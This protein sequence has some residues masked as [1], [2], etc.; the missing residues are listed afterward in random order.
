MQYQYTAYKADRVVTN[1][2]VEAVSEKMAEDFLYQAGYKYVLNLK[3]KPVKKTVSQLI[4][5][6]FGVKTRDIIDFTRQLASFLDSGS[7]LIVALELLKD[8]DTK[9]ALREVINNIISR[10]KQGIPFSQVIKENPEI[11]SFSYYQVISSCEKT[12]D[13]VKGL[14][15]IADY[16]EQKAATSE[17]IKRALVYPIFVICLAIGVVVLMIT[18]VLPPIIKLFDS[19]QADLPPFTVLALALINF[20]TEY[21]VVL[22]II[23]VAIVAGFWLLS[24]IP[25]GRLLLDKWILKTPVFGQIVLQNSLG[26]FCRTAS[27]LMMAGLSLPNIMD[28]S[29]KSASRNLVIQK[30]FYRLRTRLMQGEGLTAPISQDKLFPAMMVRMIN[31]GEKT[32]T[33]DNSLETLGKYYEDRANRRIQSLVAMIEPVMTIL[34]GL[35][36]VSI[37]L[38]MIVPIYTII[39]K[40]K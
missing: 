14:N 13:M 29:I 23:I 28:V 31:V 11:F 26:Q 1:G 21:K 2:T 7:S 33:L 12:G 30:S 3:A 17:K 18:T 16:M 4:P 10:L 39:N 34:I 40:V 37:M 36:V 20:V 22:L 25:A 32:G 6:L 15:Q 9:P 8:Q 24:R 38:S 27:M 19:F 35:V 5:S